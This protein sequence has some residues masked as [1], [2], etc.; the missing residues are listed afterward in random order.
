MRKELY[1]ALAV[2][3]TMTAIPSTTFAQSF[4]FAEFNR[5]TIEYKTG[6]KS[7][8]MTALGNLGIEVKGSVDNL[9]VL[10][11]DIDSI[12][13]LKALRNMDNLVEVAVDPIRSFGPLEPEIIEN[14]TNDP[15]IDLQPLYGLRQVQAD[16]LHEAD[17]NGGIKVCVVD[18]GYEAGHEDLPLS[19]V[20][21]SSAGAGSWFSGPLDGHG[22]HVAGTIAAM[23]NNGVGL[24]GVISNAESAVP[25]HIVRV[26]NADGGFAHASGLVGALQSCQDAGANVVNMSLGGGLPSKFEQRAFEN[27]RKE[28]MLLIAAAGNSGSATH[29]YPA[30]YDSV[31]SVAANDEDTGK[32]GFSQFTTQVEISAPGVGVGSTYVGNGYAILSGTSMASPHVAGS[33]ALVWSHYPTCSNYEIRNALKQSAMDI[34][35]PGRDYTSGFGLVQIKAAYDYLAENSCTG[36]TCR[37]QEC[38]PDR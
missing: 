3:M 7:S 24:S 22:T 13:K 33:A 1:L 32:A 15:L 16:Q 4:D 36:Q 27:F 23:G 34:G 2:A 17:P 6:D 28:G 30:S 18:S 10:S 14:Y 31:M 19:N 37:G 9:N 35:E 21:G 5:F 8:L 26:F 29:S 11:V 20:T 25:L 38:K 12:D